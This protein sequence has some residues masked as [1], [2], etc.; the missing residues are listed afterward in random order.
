[1]K[2]AM[3]KSKIP[4]IPT[5]LFIGVINIAIIGK[6]YA[7]IIIINN[8]II[9]FDMLPENIILNTEKIRFN[10]KRFAVNAQRN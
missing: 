1:M 5:F 3:G 4:N 6:I 8:V 9:K 7:Y 2:I 10:I